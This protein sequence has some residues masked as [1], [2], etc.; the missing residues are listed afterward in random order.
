MMCKTL[1]GQ[2]V[3]MIFWLIDV[4]LIISSF[5]FQLSTSEFLESSG[6][7]KSWQLSFFFGV[8][9]NHSHSISSCSSVTL[10]TSK[11]L[12][13][14]TLVLLKNSEFVWMALVAYIPRSNHITKFPLTC[15]SL[16]L[17]LPMSGGPFPSLNRCGGSCTGLCMFNAYSLRC[18]LPVPYYF[19]RKSI[20]AKNEFMVRIL[21]LNKLSPLIKHFNT[22]ILPGR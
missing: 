16:I 8:Y 6:T 1:K 17:K 20:T 3:H 21:R 15:N 2:Q 10:Q 18:H 19:L 22:L 14:A 13:P 12:T 11:I 4:N 5:K 9:L 7:D